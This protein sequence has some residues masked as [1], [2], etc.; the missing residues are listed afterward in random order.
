MRQAGKRT[1]SDAAA[2]LQIKTEGGRGGR[3]GRASQ[4]G[5]EGLILAQHLQQ[6]LLSARGGPLGQGDEG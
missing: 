4:R 2:E 5:G 3:G 1:G 6:P